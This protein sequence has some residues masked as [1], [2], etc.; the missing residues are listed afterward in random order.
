MDEPA[1][2][3]LMRV[4]LFFP[5]AGSL[6]GKRA[7]LNRVKAFLRERLHASV[8]EVGHQDSWQ[9]ST[10]AVAIAARSASIAHDTVD[11]IQ[12]ALDNRF[13]QGVR[14]EY[15]LASWTDLESLG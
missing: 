11:T 12:R 4:H 10:L 8:A 15:R 7:E 13:P 9:R 5:E 3:A 1:F 2:V 6:K 14:I